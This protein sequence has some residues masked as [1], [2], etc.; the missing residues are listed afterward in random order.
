L[1]SIQYQ[2]I[3]GLGDCSRSSCPRCLSHR[4][5]PCPRSIALQAEQFIGRRPCSGR[6]DR[7]MS[8][9]SI[10]EDTESTTRSSSGP[11]V[12]APLTQANRDRWIFNASAVGDRVADGVAIG[13]SCR[14]RPCR[15][16]RRS[17]YVSANGMSLFEFVYFDVLA[18]PW[19]P[20]PLLGPLA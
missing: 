6:A 12:D 5:P 9:F 3:R 2:D 19:R 17:K 14:N 16:R 4:G 10:F 13:R 8:S 15:Y 20:T 7:S 11:E 1:R 18:R